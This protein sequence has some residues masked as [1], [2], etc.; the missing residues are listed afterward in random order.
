MMQRRGVLATAMAAG[1]L[2]RAAGSQVF[3][4]KQLR[5]LVGA[6]PSGGIDT[7]ARIVG[8]ELS[9]RDGLSVIA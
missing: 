7:A 2:P 8:Q 4:S 6:A 1:L 5:F 3:P 9:R